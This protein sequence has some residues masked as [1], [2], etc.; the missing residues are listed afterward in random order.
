MCTEGINTNQDRTAGSLYQSLTSCCSAQAACARC[1]IS[2]SRT[3]TSVWRRASAMARLCT[4]SV[5]AGT[6]LRGTN[7]GSHT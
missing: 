5:R 7:T 3:S 4:S 2:K 6:Y 1:D